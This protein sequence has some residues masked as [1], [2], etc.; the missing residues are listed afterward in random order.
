VVQQVVVLS[1][2]DKE[3]DE[4][5]EVQLFSIPRRLDEGHRALLAATQVDWE[6]EA[7]DMFKC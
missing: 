4:Q 6:R 7:V 2:E 5:A 1:T 3:H